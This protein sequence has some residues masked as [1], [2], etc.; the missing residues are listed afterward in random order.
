MIDERKRLILN[1]LTSIKPTTQ[2]GV[3]CIVSH[4]WLK[5]ISTTL[6]CQNKSLISKWLH[7]TDKLK[8]IAYMKDQPKVRP[9]LRKELVKAL[10]IALTVLAVTL[11]HRSLHNRETAWLFTSRNRKAYSTILSLCEG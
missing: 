11:H 6:N 1:H 8:M 2:V 10:I 5:E 7:K 3:S 9:E 4:K